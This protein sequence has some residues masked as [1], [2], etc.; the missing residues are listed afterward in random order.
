VDNNVDKSLYAEEPESVDDTALGEAE[1]DIEI[2]PEQ[3]DGLEVD[4]DGGPTVDVV[5]VP[6]DGNLA[7]AMDPNVLG[8]IASDV[9]ADVDVDTR[10]RADWEDTYKRGLELL[11]LKYDDRTEPWEGACG[12][13]HPMITEAIVRFQAELV[14]E[15]F[16][17]KGPVLTKVLGKQTPDKLAAAR[18]VQEHMNY[19]LTETMTEYR[20]EH[21]R[22]LW[23]LPGAGSA[24]KKVY[25]D[26]TLGRQTSVF[27]DAKD[28]IL[29]YGCSD[30]A[31]SPRVTH[32]MYKTV[33]ELAKLKAAGFYADVDT[34]EGRPGFDDL[35][36]AQ[37]EQVGASDLEDARVK[38]YEVQVELDLEGYEDCDENGEY[39]RIAL[40]YVMTIVA[41]TNAVLGLRRNYAEDDPL[42]IKQQHFVHYQYIPGFGAYGFGLFHL[43]GGYAKASTSLLRQLVDSGTLSNLPG[44]LKSR[45]LRIKGDNTPIGPGEFRDVDVGSG[46]IQD[47]I[48]ALPYKEPSAVLAGLLEKIIEEGRRFAATADLKISDMSSQAPV[49]TTLALLERTLKV[50]SAVQARTHFSLKQEFKLLAAIMRDSAP[51]DYEFEPESGVPSAKKADFTATDIIPVSDPNAATMAQRVIQYQ[52]VIQLASSAPE[53]YDQPRLH[54]QMLEVLG[55]KDAEQLIPLD[56]DIKPSDPMSENMAVLNGKPVK[57]FMHQDHDAHIAVHTAAMQ[58]PMLMQIMG[59]NP[60][61]QTIMAAAQAHITQHVAYKYRAEMEKLLGTTLPPEDEALPPEME[62][63]LSAMMSKAAQQLLAQNKQAMA[64][65]QAQ[66]Q[67]QDPVMQMQMRELAIKEGDLELKKQELALKAED[68]KAKRALDDKRLQV[69]AADRAD[70]TAL[71]E[72]KQVAGE[73]L[74][75]QE[76][77]LKAMHYGNMGR[78]QDQSI[79]AKDRDRALAALQ[80]LADIHSGNA[81]GES[82][83]MPPTTDAAK[84][85][86]K[87]DPNAA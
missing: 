24:F 33:N 65:K 76:T 64:A 41:D 27:V 58:D 87:G 23:S 72:R 69:D 3:E 1:L 48:M 80:I 60:K 20:P 8:R 53:I 6:F 11:G 19:E 62:T 34:P 35:Q 9:L 5:V 43:I 7:E 15:T 28:V 16:P 81:L 37:D 45:G 38:L 54:R 67:A 73:E 74:S 57:A 36:Q 44:G 82:G 66:A 51:D 50:M 29:P 52:A 49:G 22:M 75:E 31:T 18:R 17:A 2:L 68:M 30:M 70:K 59:Q 39:T 77:R 26:P 21:E 32:V 13:N 84:V 78:A 25:F 40:P 4:L 61:A 71:A 46:K 85:T 47:N 10:S 83:G 63:A 79:L 55:I 56:E 86:E 12:V 14:T 42:K